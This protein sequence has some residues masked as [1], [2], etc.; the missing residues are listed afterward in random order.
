MA[1]DDDQDYLPSDLDEEAFLNQAYATDEEAYL[2][3]ATTAEDDDDEEQPDLF[4]EGADPMSVLAG[5]EAQERL[6]RQPFEVLASRKRRSR[7]ER[8]AAEEAEE[9][10]DEEAAGG[11]DAG[12]RPGPSQPRPRGVGGGGGGGGGG[13]VFGANIIRL[14]P[15]LP[16]PYHTLGLLHEAVGDV[17]KSLDFYMIAAHLTPKDISLWRRLA[18]LSADQ[19]LV[20]QAIY[21]YTQ[22][23]RRDRE[24][25][26]AR[27]DRAMLYADMG[28]NRKAIEGLE[29]VKAARPDHSEAPKALARLFHRTGQAPRAVQVLQAHLSTYPAL[30][31][32][33]HINILAELY[34]DAGQWAAALA[35]VQRA[36]RELLAPDEEL[37]IDLRVKAGTAQ[38]HLGDVAAAVEAFS[39]IL[40]EPVESFADLALA[41]QPEAGT[42]DAWARLALCHRALND[43]EGALNVYRAV[44]Q[45]L[46]PDHP[47]HIEAVVALADLHR[48][49]GQQQE[50]ESVLAGLEALIRTQ[51]MPADH[52]AALEFVLRRAN[53]FYA[54]GKNDAYLNVTV[55]VLGATLRVLEA[56]HRQ[57]AGD[58]D[59][60]LAKRLK[61]LGGR[62]ERG[63]AEADAQGVFV[64]YKRYD[65]RKKHIRELDERAEQILAATAA[66]G[67][68]PSGAESEGEDEAGPG[69]FVM[70][71]LLR[72]EAPFMMLLQTGQVLLAERQHQEARELL[73]AALDV[74]GKRYLAETG[75]V[76]AAVKFLSPMRQRH[77]TCLP[78]MLMLGHCHLLNTQYAEALCEY[79]HAYRVGH[80]EPLVL[81]CIAA[82]LVNQAATKR[83]PDRH[84]AVLQAF[85][86]LQEYG[87]ARRNPQEAAYNTGRAAHHLGLLHI[88]V[89]YYERVLEAAPPAV[90]A[91]AGPAYDLRREAALNLSLIYRQSGA[92]LLAKQLLRQHLTV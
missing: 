60:R 38:A 40:Q 18:Q 62:R 78:L 23:L 36:E 3:G 35:T 84:R 53:I 7:R 49:L 61:F 14:A 28:E 71:E 31:D 16:D 19:G 55:P 20:R 87:D 88:A 2:A 34:C 91:G 43:V 37:P 4:G 82:A 10:G 85:A 30:T 27:Y 57:V 6:G 67:G 66:G 22:V 81:L 68:A 13:G 48:E 59:P 58:V 17:K 77:P 12:G 39:L 26:D 75:G 73:Q 83:V 92:D 1:S 33:T 15:N 80:S 64:G 76:R 50:A 32:L 11:G 56:E 24:D 54:C 52:E 90:A 8:L 5:M 44:V 72:E 29:Q 47:G 69:A 51:D 9:S 21:C 74:C 86:F 46:G 79:F 63:G 41:E 42:P 25:L 65:R 70:R 89:P 45:Q